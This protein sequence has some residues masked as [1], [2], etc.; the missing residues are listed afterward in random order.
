M[1][2]RILFYSITLVLLSACQ[3]IVGDTGATATPEPPP[4]P[5]TVIQWERDP[6]Y[7]VFR[8]DISPN[9][10][11]TEAFIMGG[12]VPFC[13]IYG[14]GTVVWTQEA[15][16]S[17]GQILFGPVDDER[18]RRFIEWLTLYKEI[19]TYT[20]ELDL[21]MS[22]VTP[23]VETLYLNVNGIAHTTDALGGWQPGYF[24]EILTACAELSP[25]PQIYEPEGAWVSAMEAPFDNN[26]NSVLWE[27][28]VTGIDLRAIADSGAPQWVTGRGLQLLWTY[29]KRSSPDLQFGQL[30]GNF[31]VILQ[32][33]NITRVYP[34]PTAPPA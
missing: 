10:D 25:Q 15:S 7:I 29:L 19:Y 5:N 16:S 21:D 9:P 20:A 34:T 13:T 18:I 28:S 24:A 3:S 14:D 12:E 23:V 2:L 4:N 6:S 8:A 11:P 1:R 31:V 30:D 33:Q 32:I 22:S 26:A 27:P 17:G